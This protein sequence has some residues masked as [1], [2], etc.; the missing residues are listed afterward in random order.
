MARS[1]GPAPGRAARISR[2]RDADGALGPGR[3]L[4]IRS[5]APGRIDRDP[6]L[7]GAH[8]T[9]A[10]ARASAGR[11]VTAQPC[12]LAYLHVCGAQAT[13]I[14][15]ATAR[16]PSAAK[17]CCRAPGTGLEGLWLHRHPAA[18][19]RL[20]ARSGWQLLWGDPVAQPDGLLHGPTAFARR[21]PELHVAALAAALRTHRAGPRGARPVLRLGASLR[22]W[23]A[24]AARRSGSSCRARR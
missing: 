15:K 2:P 16:R 22:E 10:G 6:R 5:R 23:T 24:G 12:P 11:A 8:G 7:P 14:V 21:C 19:R 9:R 3:G 4:A 18:G 1:S 20:F 17:A 13:L